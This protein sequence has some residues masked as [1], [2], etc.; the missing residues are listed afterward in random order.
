MP[1]MGEGEASRP[2]ER[3]RQDGQVWDSVKKTAFVLGTGLL[4]FAAFRNSVTWH[5]QQFWGASGDFWQSQWGKLHGFFDGNQLTLFCLG[6]MLIP[7]LSFW[8]FNAILMLIDLTGKPYFITKYRIQ[9][10]KNE[11]VDPVKLRQAV[12]TV[13]VNQVFLSFPMIVLMYPIMLWRG[14][15]C[16]P[17]LPTFHWVLLELSVFALV[18][19]I[20]FYYS[21]RLVHHPLLYK[22]IHKKHHEWTAPVGVVCLYAHPLEHIFSNMLPSMVG[23]MIMGSHVATT[24]LWF[25]LALITTT[26]S[27]CGYHLPFLPSP[28]FHDFHH[29]KFNQ[30][31]GVL[32]VLDH[33]HGTDQMFKQTKAHERHVLLM[34]LTPLS[35]SIPDNPKK[36]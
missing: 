30:C 29:L 27:H 33:L 34:S 18:E 11:P 13:L 3:R 31:Y 19:E 7:T 2:A 5:L 25:A 8:I 23:P 22:R 36:C 12:I 32:G 4:I 24:M 1:K 35:Q 9:L 16:G 26:I 21:H 14:N 28:E 15:P 17:E 20:L 6:T 10:G